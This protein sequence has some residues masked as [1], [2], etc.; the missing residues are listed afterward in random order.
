MLKQTQ[1]K[2]LKTPPESDPSK[3]SRSVPADIETSPGPE[4]FDDIRPK[5]DGM[6]KKIDEETPGL[7]G[8]WLRRVSNNMACL[9][10]GT[11]P[12]FCPLLA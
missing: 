9:L 11:G 1:E 10:I 7:T 2:N 5:D 6:A 8:N 12:F 3:E 4:D